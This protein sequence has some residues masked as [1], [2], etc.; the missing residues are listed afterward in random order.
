MPG[1]GSYSFNNRP[2]S[3]GPLFSFGNEQKKGNTDSKFD[4][5][6]GPGQY[7]YDTL[8]SSQN[9]KGVTI[10]QR[11]NKNHTNLSNLPG[12]G[13]YESN[14]NRPASGAKIGRA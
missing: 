7:D 12:P 13:Q 14:L 10:G 8:K 5:I 1:P 9:I 4:Y 3:A 6:P 2:T 11:F